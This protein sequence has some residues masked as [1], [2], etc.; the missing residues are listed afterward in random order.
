[1]ISFPEFSIDNLKIENIK[2]GNADISRITFDIPT[3]SCCFACSFYDDFKCIITGIDKYHHNER[4]KACPFKIKEWKEKGER[5][6]NK[7]R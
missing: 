4:V 7:E 1:M 6:N 3:P 2:R 5:K